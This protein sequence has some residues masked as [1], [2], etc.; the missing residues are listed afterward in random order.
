MRARISLLVLLLAAGA[1]AQTTAGRIVGTIQDHTGAVV[2]GA[3]VKAVN[4]ETGAERAAT[5]NP[6]GQYL[7]YPLPPGTYRMTA[8][9][10]GFRT[11][12]WDGIRIDVADTVVRN[13]SLKVGPLEQTVTVSAEAAPMLTQNISVESTI[14]REQI[15]SLPLNS[16]D[17][18]Q[19]VLLAQGAV[20]TIG[21]GN[22]DF[23]G[24]A[25]N[26]NRAFSNDYLLDG[27]PNNDLYQGRS[28]APVSVDLIREF[29]VT[30]GVAAAE[31]GQ[32][33]T[34]VSI[35]SRGG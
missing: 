7:L 20:E 10:E 33:G 5:S 1:A 14:V 18:T 12:T 26:G 17:F 22:R 15:D 16:R 9:M 29:K 23:G 28:A 13:L 30:S 24:V 8:Q 6:E 31:Y 34:Q 35:V 27:T 32:A 25:L 19:L 11:E 2:P 3:A 4:L 21:S